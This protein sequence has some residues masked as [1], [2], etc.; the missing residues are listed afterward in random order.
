MF[1]CTHGL[2]HYPKRNWV[3]PYISGSHRNKK[4]LRNFT[5][6]FWTN[7]GSSR[8]E[9]FFKKG[10]LRNFTKFT[11]KHL[12]QGLFFNKV[13]GLRTPFFIEHLW[14]LLLQFLRNLVETKS[15]VSYKKMRV[16]LKVKS[17]AYSHVNRF[18]SFRDVVFRYVHCPVGCCTWLYFH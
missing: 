5:S 8:P 11:R 16:N 7:S 9:V 17:V 14:W 6:K 13:A 15:L 2:I 3:L 18:M 12:C 4:P 10:V 1:L